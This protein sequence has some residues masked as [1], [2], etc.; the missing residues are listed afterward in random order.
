MIKITGDKTPTFHLNSEKT[1]YIFGV[2]PSG[3]LSHF[4]YGALL[5][6]P[7]DLRAFDF[8]PALPLGSSTQFTHNNETLDL[9]ITLVECATYGKGDYKTPSLHLEDHEGFRSLI[10]LYQ[11]YEII[12]NHHIE[13][14]PQAEKN[15]TLKVIL[16]EKDVDIVVHLFYTIYDDYNVI[17]RSQAVI[18]K[19]SEPITIDKV[20]SMN[21]DIAKEDL[22]LITFDG[23]WIKERTLNRRVLYHGIT[24]IDS[25]KG[26]SSADH[27][28]FFMVLDTDATL[29]HGNVYGFN[30]IY[31]GSFEATIEK[32][33]HGIIRI[34][35]GINSF[36]FKWT[37]NPNESF[38]TPEAVL[39]F[40][41][42]GINHLMQNLH[43]FIEKA[44]IKDKSL[45]PVLINNWEATYFDINEKK[46]LAIAKHAKK[47]GIEGIVLD[48]GWFG[49]RDDDTTSLGDW[50]AHPKKFKHGLKKL[51]QKIK[52][53]GLLFGLWVEPE[54]VSPKSD[55]YKNHPEWAIKHPTKTPSLGRNQ[56]MLDLTNPNVVDYLTQTLIALFKEARVDYVKW[57][58]N[59][60]LS[61]AYSHY[62][63]KL[64]QGRFHYLYT[65]GLYQLLS[66]LKKACPNVLFESCASGGN[67]FDLGM[68]AYMPQTWTSDNTDAYERLS[69]QSSTYMGYPQHTVSNH[70]NDDIAHQTLRAIP[71]HTR[72]HVAMFGVLGLELDVRNLTPFNKAMI[73]HHLNLYK[74]H[75]ALF[76]Q[77]TFCIL[78]NDQNH[79]VFYVLSED[80]KEAILGDFYGLINPNDAFKTIRLT[81]LDPNKYYQ[82]KGLVTYENI[83]R[84]KSLVKHALPIKLNPDGI[85]FH[86]LANRYKMKIEPFDQVF[87]GDILMEEGLPL[88]HG[89][90]GTGYHESMRL[91]LDFSSRLYYIKEVQH[92]QS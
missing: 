56:L 4:Y 45:R 48:D 24:T 5:N 73:K 3:V 10:F 43:K 74:T 60:N 23:A 41:S 30:L 13:G 80:S 57:D 39:S 2:L 70:V 19:T 69:I 20:A 84:F 16:K 82:V 17:V 8:K 38:E 65:L 76:Q 79:K 77:G 71:L 87:K 63:D 50:H 47:L 88:P 32:S 44:I 83:N 51:S 26:V 89:F 42:L 18:N 33:H 75:R 27:N 64:A 7:I 35:E 81:N 15:E 61:D 9:N 1:S 34:N 67:R 59:R 62:L 72:F 66:N 55:L 78:K 86:L 68:L 31:S 11:G 53:Q 54:M 58:M 6:E 92:E 36:D 29:H 25:K 14:L 85:L 28:P 37:L 46:F 52:R 40:S 91:L 21:L 22:D 49:N 90:T 12:K